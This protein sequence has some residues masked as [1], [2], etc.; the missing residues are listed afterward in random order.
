MIVVLPVRPQFVPATMSQIQRLRNALELT[1]DSI[2]LINGGA[3]GG[4]PLLK[5]Y[6]SIRKA[7]AGAN[8]W[9]Y[10]DVIAGRCYRAGWTEI[11]TAR[12]ARHPG[13]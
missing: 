9:V 7:A 10:R 6:C 1:D 5:I 4:G 13:T 8:I 3:R 2:I 11:Q 12:A